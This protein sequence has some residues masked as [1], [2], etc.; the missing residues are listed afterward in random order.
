MKEHSV[1][2][3]LINHANEFD[4]WE[5]VRFVLMEEILEDSTP[6]CYV[7]VD[8]AASYEGFAQ[9][10]LLEPLRAKTGCTIPVLKT[11]DAL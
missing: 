7:P 9:R 4:H 8:D 11:K 1:Y 6:P 2:S 10:H 3:W 5:K